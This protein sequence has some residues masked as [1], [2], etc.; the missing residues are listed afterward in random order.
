MTQP[1]TQRPH[2]ADKCVIGNDRNAFWRSGIKA[3][4]GLFEGKYCGASHYVFIQARHLLL[5]SNAYTQGV[6]KS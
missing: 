6:G 2:F 4:D 5:Q 1:G 3:W